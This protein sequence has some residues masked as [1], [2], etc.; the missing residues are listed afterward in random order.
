M[1]NINYFINLIQILIFLIIFLIFYKFKKV[2]NTNV[3]LSKINN[4]YLKLNKDFL[5]AVYN[6]Y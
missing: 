1:S 2:N 5:I 3:F 4:F 6:F